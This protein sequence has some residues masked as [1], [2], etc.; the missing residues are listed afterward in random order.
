[1]SWV[2]ARFA[3]VILALALATSCRRDMQDQPKV[4]PLR[5]S[6]F[7]ADGS[8]ARP[9]VEDTVARGHLRADAHLETGKVDGKLVETFPFPITR[10][11]LDRGQQRFEIFCTPCHGRAGDGDGMVVQRGLRRPPSWNTDR[12]RLMPVGHFFDVTT[13]GFG[14]MQDY[15]A[16]ISV[17][18]RWAIVAYIRALQLSQHATVDDVPPAERGSLDRPGGA[19]QEPHR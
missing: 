19:A 5:P 8:S 9:L 1:M 16:Q 2:P 14:V 17:Y 6:S 7:F 4:R 11:V 12:L 15:R 18:D 10:E 13:N 3:L